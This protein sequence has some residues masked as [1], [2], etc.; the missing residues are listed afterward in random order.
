[1]KSKPLTRKLSPVR[2]LS[3]AAVQTKKETRRGAL[4]F[5]IPFHG[6]TTEREREG[7][8]HHGRCLLLASKAINNYK[9]NLTRFLC[10]RIEVL[11]KISMMDHKQQTT[12]LSGVILHIKRGKKGGGGG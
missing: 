11:K 4:T 1:M 3:H 9:T 2:I 12:M 7:T 8:K 10:D 5:Q 6:R